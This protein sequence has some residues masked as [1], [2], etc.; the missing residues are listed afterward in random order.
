[1]SLCYI[2][3]PGMFREFGIVFSALNVNTRLAETRETTVQSSTR[4]IL[5]IN[6][7]GE[8]HPQTAP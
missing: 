2:I 5:D 3:L 8:L 7:R 6:S 4:I 1:M